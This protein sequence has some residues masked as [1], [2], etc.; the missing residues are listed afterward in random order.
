MPNYMWFILATIAL[1]LGYL[2]YG[3]IVEKIFVP[4]PERNT[5]AVSKSDGVDFVTM[6]K[7]KLWL[8]QLVSIAGGGPGCGPSRGA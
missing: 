5:P 3:R 2:I 1:V 7:W 6:P 8:S 4:N